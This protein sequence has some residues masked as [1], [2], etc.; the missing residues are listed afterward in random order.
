MTQARTGESFLT[1]A[2]IVY[3]SL[4]T[5]T[6]RIKNLRPLEKSYNDH[7]KE[8]LGPIDATLGLIDVAPQSLSF[9]VEKKWEFNGQNSR[10]PEKELA[11]WRKSS[12]C[13]CTSEDIDVD[14]ALRPL[15][16][17]PGHL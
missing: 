17:G 13:F 14:V 15:N 1:V 12:T 2:F 3:L 9:S 6:R 7:V 5:G 16:R 11:S 4:L 10:C 8:T